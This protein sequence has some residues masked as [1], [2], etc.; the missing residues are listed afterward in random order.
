M[1]NAVAVNIIQTV[2]ATASTKQL[3]SFVG[4]KADNCRSDYVLCDQRPNPLRRYRLEC[5]CRGSPMIVIDFCLKE[6]NGYMSR[7]RTV[8]VHERAALL[9]VIA[10]ANHMS[11]LCS[12]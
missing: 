8:R 4:H 5:F 2:S 7:R 3:Q 12:G 10:T 11:I 9:T 6:C 1:A